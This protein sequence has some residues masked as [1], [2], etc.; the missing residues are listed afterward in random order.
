MDTDWDVVVIGSGLGGLSA[1]LSLSE[2]GQKVLVLE[3][4]TTPGGCASSFQKNGYVFE[5]GATTLVGMEPGLPFHKLSS[6]FQIQFPLFPL[7]RS[8]LVHLDEKTVE[9]YQDRKEWTLEAKRVF[10]GGLR[11]EV[12]WKL[13]DLISDSLWNLSCRYKYFPFK[14]LSDVMKSIG[15][16]RPFDLLVLFFSFVSLRFVLQCLGLTKNKD[17][18]RFLEEQLLITSQTTSTKVPMVFAAAGL[19]YPQLKNYVVKG[20]MVSLAETIIKKIESNGG[21]VLYKQEVTNLKKITTTEGN[22]ENFW[23]LRTKHRENFL[24]RA[25]LVVSNLPIWNLTEITNDLPKL[26]KKTTKFENGIWGAFSM[27]IA[28]QTNPTEEWTKTECLHHQIHMKNALPFGGGKSIFLSLSH[29]E[30]SIRSPNGIRILS[31]STHIANPESWIRD[32]FY[33]EKK[34]RMESIVIQTI[35]EKFPWFQKD[36]ILF[37]HSA[38]PVTWK[39]WT[40]RKFGRVGGIPNSFFS[41]PFKM[42]SNRSE[43]P[44]LLLTGDTVYPGQG[45]PAVVL[46]GLHAVEQFLERKRG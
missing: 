17:W 20:G 22:L 30:D 33:P 29:P 31:I 42:L 24:F 6:E 45:I 32:D 35:E 44:S 2:N 21:K 7:N 43:D 8:M 10:G 16:F 38:T 9:R 15:S 5:S 25:S 41:N 3:K 18:I 27:G 39:T 11:M 34:K 36:K 1:A 12:F 37:R 14:N 28:I 4:G 13:C 23:E 26:K 40:G 46:G 19:T